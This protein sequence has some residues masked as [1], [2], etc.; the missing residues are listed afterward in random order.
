MIVVQR[1]WSQNFRN[2]N[3]KKTDENRGEESER[4]A[5]AR[6]RAIGYD[7][8]GGLVGPQWAVKGLLA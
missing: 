7:G 2:I 1:W 6:A 4:R 3:R 8:T 5:R